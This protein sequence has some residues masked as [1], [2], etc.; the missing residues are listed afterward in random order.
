MKNEFLINLG[1]SIIMICVL[2]GI[3]VLILNQMGIDIQQSSQITY[4]K[5]CG[6]VPCSDTYYD[7][8]TKTCKNVFEERQNYYPYSKF[9]LL[10]LI[11]AFGTALLLTFLVRFFIPYPEYP[12][13]ES[14][15]FDSYDT[16][17]AR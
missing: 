2:I 1:I 12:V 8:E 13:D 16:G 6:G 10:Y 3:T 17:E 14:Q 7:E 4:E 11:I 15:H 9:S 5:C